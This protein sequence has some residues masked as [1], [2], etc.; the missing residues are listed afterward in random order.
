MTDVTKR[1]PSW[2]RSRMT[3]IVLDTSLLVAFLA[4]FITREGPD[5]ALHSWIGILLIPVIVLHLAGNKA[6]IMR[7]WTR[8]RQ[9]R[10]FGLGV[11][12]VVLGALTGVCI[13]TGFPLW[14]E[15]SEASAWSVVH[16]LTGMLAILV[17]FVHLGKN[18]SRISR[19][20]R[21]ATG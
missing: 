13:A 19:L 21:G 9:D 1:R 3:K 15:W 14:L 20:A 4:E 6:W 7:V 16:Q 5:F 18:R 8:G 11:L 17:M 2:L 12:N 10:E